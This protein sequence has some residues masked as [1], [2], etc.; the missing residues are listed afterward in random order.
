MVLTEPK[1][2]EGK[3]FTILQDDGQ[4]KHAEIVEAIKDHEY[5]NEQAPSTFE[6]QVFNEP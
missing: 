1:D 3:S 6:V 4:L 2:P 5:K